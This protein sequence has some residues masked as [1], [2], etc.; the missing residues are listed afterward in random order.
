MGSVSVEEVTGRAPFRHFVELPYML[1]REEPRWSPPLIAHERSRLDPARNP[2]FEQGDGAYFLARTMG[3]VSGRITAHLASAGDEA[4]WFGFFDVI[5]DAATA[6]ELVAS[7]IEWLRDR[8][9]TTITGPASFTLDDEAGVLVEGH[10]V[11]GTTGRPWHPPWYADHLR[12]AGLRD[13]ATGERRTWRLAAAAGPSGAVPARRAAPALAGP[14][15]DERLLL[16]VDGGTIDAVPDLTPARVAALAMAKLARRRAWT[17]C[18]VV[19]WDGEPSRLV[20]ALVHAA[21][22]AGYEWVVTPWSPDPD[23]PPETVHRLLAAPI[24]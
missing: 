8:G 20:P 12:A 9:C 11:A 3:R 6:R 19:S 17:G 2:F 1:H 5:D 7:A 16:D 22:A 23:A 21:A 24:A 13:V 4:G 14:Y 10:D 18:T 15:A